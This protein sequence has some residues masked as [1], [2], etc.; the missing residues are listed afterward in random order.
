MRSCHTYHVPVY[1]LSGYEQRLGS[2][3]QSVLRGGIRR[4]VGHLKKMCFFSKQ[5]AILRGVICPSVNATLGIFVST[6]II[7]T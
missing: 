1:Y 2:F 6:F 7:L 4:R 3:I 5:T